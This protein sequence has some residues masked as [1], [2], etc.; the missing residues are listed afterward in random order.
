MFASQKPDITSIL[1]EK[2]DRI[3]EEECVPLVHHF[4]KNS[5]MEL[6]LKNPFRIFSKK[7]ACAKNL[8]KD[9]QLFK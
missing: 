4:A 1:E 5:E 3:E 7:T 6:E 2:V 8:K 9:L